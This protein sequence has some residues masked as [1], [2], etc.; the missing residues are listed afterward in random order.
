MSKLK[1]AHAATFKTEVKIPVPAGEYLAV[2][3]E[4]VWKN[5]PALVEL[6]DKLKDSSVSDS[7][8]VL[9][10]VKSW[11]FD[12]ELNAENISYLLN[13][14]PQSG[15]AIIDAYYLAYDGAREKN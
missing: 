1:L 4:F 13:E 7:E 5:R 6:G 15:V 8:I 10:I 14:Y 9:D 3:F 11:G 2:E 12:D